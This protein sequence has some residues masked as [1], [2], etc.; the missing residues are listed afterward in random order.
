M[1]C[2]IIAHAVFPIADIMRYGRDFL[3]PDQVFGRARL[4]EYERSATAC[5]LRVCRL[6][7]LSRETRPT[8]A[9]WRG[10]AAA[11]R[12]EVEALLGREALD[13]FVDST[14]VLEN[15]WDAQKLGCGMMVAEKL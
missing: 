13:R 14:L 6:V 2:D 7:D 12:D 1:L 9:S 4:E 5:G 3:L 11:F 15:F 8:F 10:N